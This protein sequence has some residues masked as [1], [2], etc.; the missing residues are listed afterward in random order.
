[1]RARKSILVYVN[2]T[3]SEERTRGHTAA[4]HCCMPKWRNDDEISH[5]LLPSE[6][7]DS[8][9]GECALVVGCKEQMKL[10]TR[11]TKKTRKTK[12]SGLIKLAT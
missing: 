1:M 2:D 12:G 11:I 8:A 6:D 4:R 7:I 10:L 3:C 5:V 9:A